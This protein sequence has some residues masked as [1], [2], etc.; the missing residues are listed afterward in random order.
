M[1]GREG[2]GDFVQGGIDMVSTL[3]SLK[4]LRWFR[5]LMETFLGGGGAVLGIEPRT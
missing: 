4:L 1:W 5:I 2:T 3:F